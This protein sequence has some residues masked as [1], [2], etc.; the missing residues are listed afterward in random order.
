MKIVGGLFDS[1]EDMT[2]ALEALDDADFAAFKVFGPEELFR[3]PVAEEEVEG[4]VESQAHIAAGG[5][6]GISVNP[7]PYVPGDPSA[8]TVE[9]DL[10]SLGLSQAMAE[11]FVAGLQQE[12]LLLL[13]Q[14]KAGRADEA[15]QIMEAQNARAVLQHHPEDAF[16]EE[17]WRQPR[18]K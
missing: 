9:D 15:A 16:P 13:V 6:S 8:Q 11:V 1:Q 3:E 5:A 12:N 17:Q 7:N 10:L 2:L 18:R 4:S 14:T